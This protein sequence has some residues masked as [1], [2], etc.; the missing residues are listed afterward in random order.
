MSKTKDALDLARDLRQ[1]IS[2]NDVLKGRKIQDMS[3]RR[4]SQS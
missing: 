4:A 3:L 1:E 2:D